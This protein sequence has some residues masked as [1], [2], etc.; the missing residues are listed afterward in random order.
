M[1]KRFLKRLILL[2]SLR[3]KSLSVP[4]YVT[5]LD[6]K[7]Y[8]EYN[9]KT[10]IIQKFIEGHTQGNYSGNLEQMLE[11]VKYLGI[12]VNEDRTN[13]RILSK[14]LSFQIISGTQYLSS[15]FHL[16]KYV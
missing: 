10:V 14:I 9:D 13:H 1:G 12:I 4:E 8:F 7:Q 15:F 2:I 5:C 6:G 16:F 11:S 3:S